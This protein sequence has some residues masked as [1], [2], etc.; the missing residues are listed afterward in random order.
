M[1]STSTDDNDLLSTIL[2]HIDER[3]DTEEL[4]LSQ[5]VRRLF[6]TKQRPSRLVAKLLPQTELVALQDAYKVILEHVSMVSDDSPCLLSIK[7]FATVIVFLQLVLESMAKIGDTECL[8]MSASLIQSMQ[9]SICALSP[10][11]AESDERDIVPLNEQHAPSLA[12]FFLGAMLRSINPYVSSIP[13]LL[14]PLWKSLCDVALKAPHVISFLVA[15]LAALLTVYVNNSEEEEDIE[16]ILADVFAA[17]VRVRG[18]SKA[19]EFSSATQIPQQ[20]LQSY[21]SVDKKID[22][23]VLKVLT[24][25]ETLNQAAVKAF[26]ALKISQKPCFESRCSRFGKLSMLQTMLQNTPVDSSSAESLL[27]VAEQAIFSVLPKSSTELLVGDKCFIDSSILLVVVRAA[28]HLDPASGLHV[29]L[30]LIRWLSRGLHPITREAVVTVVQN[31][32]MALNCIATRGGSPRSSIDAHEKRLEGPIL[33]LMSNLFFD[34]ELPPAIAKVSPA[35]RV[36]QDSPRS[37]PRKTPKVDIGNTLTL[38]DWNCILD[39]VACLDFSSNE[40]LEREMRS[41]T[42]D[43]GSRDDSIISTRIF[44]LKGRSPLEVALLVAGAQH[45]SAI[46]LMG[47]FLTQTQRRK[48]SAILTTNGTILT[49]SMLRFLGRSLQQ[50][51]D[52]SLVG[53]VAT[54]LTWTVA[55]TRRLFSD[56][57]DEHG[58]ALALAAG[59][60]LRR[61]SNATSPSTPS[62]VLKQIAS[63]FNELLNLS[64]WPVSANAMTCLTEFASTIPKTHQDILPLCLPLDAQ[65]LFTCRL[66]GKV[67]RGK[68]AHRADEFEWAQ[69]ASSQRVMKLIPTMPPKSTPFA[70]S[71]AYTL[72]PGSYLLSM[73]TIEGSGRSA[74][75]IFPPGEQSLN[76]IKH[77]LQR[78]KI[79][80][81]DVRQLHRVQLSD[82]GGGCRLYSEQYH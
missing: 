66:Q 79:E 56:H 3:L 43:V 5:C 11:K 9:R 48:S 10:T 76:D 1:S 55:Q 71:A 68:T 59:E 78:D 62:D 14:S 33:I 44:Y 72:A 63:C 34:H 31:Y 61:V 15:R 67:H 82:N 41:F 6:N 17:V 52:L 22:Q 24:M 23:C 20:V 47:W 80:G 64:L 50:S 35:V 45:Q 12:G 58:V 77:M 39:V 4:T 18:I 29:R 26:V 73:P 57:R 30:M 32:V 37:A 36:P 28:V 70:T 38:T 65:G 8:E 74:I 46:K 69:S 21:K 49:C 7:V 25:K 27:L 40:L 81:E 51:P 42:D 19:L 53:P 2:S 75:V 54:C 16:N 60:A 13:V